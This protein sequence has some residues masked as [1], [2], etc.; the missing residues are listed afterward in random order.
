MANFFRE[1]DR[2]QRFLLPVDM[3]DWVSETDMVHLLLDAVRLMDLSSFE[4]HYTR[5][6]SG[7]PP[8]AP[9]MM[10]CVLLYAYANGQRSSRKIERLCG[11]DAGFRMIVGD[12]VPDHSVVAR[13]RKRHRDDL[14][15]LF[16]EVLKLCHR[17]GLVR[18]GVVA[19]DGTKVAANAS[20]SANR[21][22]SSLEA[23]VAAMLSEAD[24]IDADEDELYG[25]SRGDELPAEMRDPSS[26]RS[27]LHACQARLRAEAQEQQARQQDKI[28]ARAAEEKATGKSKRGR[29]PKPP[30]EVVDADAKANVTDPDSRIMKGRKGYLQGYNAQAVVTRDQIIL[31][32]DVT[33]QANDVRQLVPMIARALAVMEAVTGDEVALGT[34]LFDA[35]YW[36]EDNAATQTAKCEYLIATTKDWKQR[37]ALRDAPP[38]RGRCPANMDAR[39]RMERKLLTKRGRDLYRLRGQTVE[40]VFGQMKEIQGA[41]RFMMHGSQ[42]TKGEWSLHC[43]AHNLR[44]LHSESVHRGKKGGKWLQN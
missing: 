5:R 12:E 17:A 11:R 34:G 2:R 7:A 32:P 28:D 24:A 40:P 36:S 42:E 31:A 18:L 25:E 44:K 13:F 10:V 22:A 33:S 3:A 8:F 14:E 23:E 6:G 38:P 9:W 30:E 4:A 39:E 19:L 37:K 15:A 21:T 26:R 43:A 29:K 35:G 41:D 27:R 20:L 16:V 1:P